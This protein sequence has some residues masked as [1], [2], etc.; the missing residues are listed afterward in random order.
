MADSERDETNDKNGR[1]T[2]TQPARQTARQTDSSQTNRWTDRRV[3]YF[4]PSLV[5]PDVLLSSRRRRR[6]L[7]FISSL[8]VCVCVWF[9]WF[10]S[11]LS[12]I[13]SSP[14]FISLAFRVCLL[15]LDVHACV[16]WWYNAQ[17]SSSSSSPPP[18]PLLSSS[19]FFFFSM[20]CWVC[21][22]MSVS[23]INER[24][25]SRPR[26]T[27]E[28]SEVIENRIEKHSERKICPYRAQRRMSVKWHDKR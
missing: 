9:S 10:F 25:T 16:L 5:L 1:N 22:V 4:L 23:A 18:P 12:R 8:H 2:S 19:S 21:L 3:F 17:S 27:C 15:C 11:F 13:F 6:R 14:F 28:R 26:S 20:H 24:E 7:F